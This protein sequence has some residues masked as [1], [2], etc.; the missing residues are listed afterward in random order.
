MSTIIDVNC[1]AISLIDRK[2]LK[3]LD[4]P[5]E[6]YDGQLKIKGIGSSKSSQFCVTPIFID[7]TKRDENGIRQKRKVRI[8]VEFHVIDDLNESF[9]LGMDIIGTYQIDI[10]T[11]KA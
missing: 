6:L 8:L 2:L 4:P 7:V 10:L 3:T 1:A 9:V 5:P 11:L